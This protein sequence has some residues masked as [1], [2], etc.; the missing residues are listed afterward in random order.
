MC[1]YELGSAHGRGVHVV[2]T[3]Q[4]SYQQ[5]EHFWCFAFAIPRISV[6]MIPCVYWRVDCTALFEFDDMTLQSTAMHLDRCLPLFRVPQ[7]C[8]RRLLVL[9]GLQ[10]TP[11][12]EQLEKVTATT[13][14]QETQPARLLR[15]KHRHTIYAPAVRVGSP[16][17]V[18]CDWLIACQSPP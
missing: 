17:D 10:E 7:G 14:G 8:I 15:S 2:G 1:D 11:R 3:R 5:Q 4:H 9:P 16:Q 13:R 18:Q 6:S 12:V